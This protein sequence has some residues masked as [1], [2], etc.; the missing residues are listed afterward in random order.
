MSEIL[1]V[2]DLELLVKMFQVLKTSKLGSYFTIRLLEFS[3]HVHMRKCMQID[4]FCESTLSIHFLDL[5][6][7]YLIFTIN[8][9]QKLLCLLFTLIAD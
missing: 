9:L 3:K 5:L 4:C 1:N 6:S 8:L 2:H 7:I